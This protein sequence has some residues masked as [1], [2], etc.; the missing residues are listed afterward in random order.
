MTLQ[1]HK[2]HFNALT[3]I[4]AIAAIMIFVYHNR[5]YWK[6]DIHP[7]LFRF[8]NELHLGVPLFFVLSGFLI[9]KSYGTKPFENISNYKNYLLQRIMRIMPL[10]WLLITLYYLDSDFGNQKFS[11]LHYLLLHGFSSSHSLEV[12]AQ[13]WSLTV[14]MTFYFLAPLLLF[15]VDKR[16]KYGFYFVLFLFV[17]TLA[18]GNLWRVLNGNPDNYF[19]PLE[20]VLMST[21]SGQ[22]IL[23]LAGI[24]YAKYESII[25]K[26]LLNKNATLI[27]GLSFIVL[28]YGIGFFQ[29]NRTDHGTN[30]WEGK[31]LFFTLLPTSIV[32]LFHGLIHEKTYLQKFLASKFMLLLGNASFAFY[33]IHISYVNLKVKSFIFLPDRN[34]CL[35]WLLAILLYYFFEKPI[36]N[37]YRNK[38]QKNS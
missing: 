13:A 18:I 35:L 31:M 3:G 7:E 30:H 32:L 16:T 14:E 12:I 5:K 11:A 26:H 24:L 19:Q 6:D 25:T 2:N 27:G 38:N 1:T 33:L 10:Y 20:F 34:F 4:R 21:F 23:F 8:C 28:I 22:S 9:A 29:V 37:W 36:Y 17:G 15:L